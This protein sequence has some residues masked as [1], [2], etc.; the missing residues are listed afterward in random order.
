MNSNIT[1]QFLT[2]HLLTLQDF[3]KCS[4]WLTLVMRQTS[5]RYSNSSHSLSNKVTPIRA[6]ASIRIW[7][8]CLPHNQW[9][10]YWTLER[11]EVLTNVLQETVLWYYCSFGHN[12][13]SKLYT[14][15]CY[16]LYIVVSADTPEKCGLLGQPQDTSLPPRSRSI[17]IYNSWPFPH[18]I[19]RCV[20]SAVET[21]H[22]NGP[23]LRINQS[24]VIQVDY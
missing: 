5:R 9:Q 23:L 11:F 22:L 4:I 18:I 16:N 21:T 12:K 8:G 19:R 15:F 3:Y 14:L 20:I 6:M 24:L 1:T 7:Y 10:P 2:E 13:F 17:Y